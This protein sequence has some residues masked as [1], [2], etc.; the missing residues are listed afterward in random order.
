M[1]LYK[2]LCSYSLT[3]LLKLPFCISGSLIVQYQTNSFR[4]K[5]SQ[6]FRIRPDR[7]AVSL[8][9]LGGRK[10]LCCSSVLHTG[11][12]VP[13]ITE[14]RPLP[15]VLSKELT[16]QWALPASSLGLLSLQGNCRSAEAVL[17][18]RWWWMV[19]QQMSRCQSKWQIL[20]GWALQ[21]GHVQARHRR[22]RGMDEL[23]GILV[24]NE[25]DVYED[26]TLLPAAVVP[27][28]QTFILLCVTFF[29][30]CCWNGLCYIIS[31]KTQNNPWLCLFRKGGG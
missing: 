7:S 13:H 28:V 4:I 27:Q 17:K 6:L 16:R 2:H 20:L 26:Q 11:Q 29:T 18:R 5:Q 9:L 19:V 23:E 15:W 1:Y 10:D 21:L 12:E 30:L 22:R 24:L 14:H 25:E 3:G 8:F 31:T